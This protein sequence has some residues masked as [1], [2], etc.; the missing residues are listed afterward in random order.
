MGLHFPFLIFEAKGNAA[1]FGAQNQAAIGAACMLRILDLVRCGRH[2]GVERDDRG[3]DPR[4]VGPPS[5]CGGQVP[6][7]PRGGVA[8]H[9]HGGGEGLCGRH[10]KGTVLGEYG[11][12]T[13]NTAGAGC[14]RLEQLL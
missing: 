7:R 12:R 10:G 2:G 8:G 3:A 14:R 9:E 5:R 4:A 11:V 13:E 1:L 6:E